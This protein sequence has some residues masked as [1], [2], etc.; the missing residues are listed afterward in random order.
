MKN[1]LQKIWITLLITALMGLN[2]SPALGQEGSSLEVNEECFDDWQFFITSQISFNEFKE[3]W[4]DI[5]VRYNK[6]TC[7]YM[8]IYQLVKQLDAISIQIK[9]AYL[10][11]NI[12]QTIKLNTK[13]LELKAEIYY[14]RNFIDIPGS[15]VQKIPDEKIFKLMRSEF[16]LNSTDFTD[17]E[18]KTL[19]DKFVSK[20]KNKI[21]SK[22]KEC[23]DADIET[24]KKKWDSFVKNIKSMG[25]TGKSLK[26]NW[27]KATSLPSKGM[28]NLI[29]G[30]ENMRLNNLPSI[31]SPDEIVKDLLKQKAKSGSTEPTIVETQTAII[32]TS[33][34][35]IRK[36]GG[37][38]LRSQYEAKYKK[39]NDQVSSDYEKKI[40]QIIDVV[41]STYD[42][43]T[44]LKKCANKSG[45][46]QCQ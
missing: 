8:D 7:H 6:N 3:F 17:E 33:E 14:L 19:F 36:V 11:C 4:E 32:D 31:K 34:E 43:L 21:T 38:S 46:R 40:Q 26:D 5:F 9:D 2:I 1:L 44:K 41:T 27:G 29:K 42:P 15:D 35:F 24:L 45:E 16:V 39:G 12:D 28:D 13:Y 37:A 10:S 20:Y 22:Y 23:K 18:L 30:L 25:D